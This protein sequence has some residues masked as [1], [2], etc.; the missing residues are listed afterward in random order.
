[1]S[2]S[3]SWQAR[4]RGV[5]FVNLATISWATNAVLGSWLRDD[6]GPLPL[7]GAVLGAALLDEPLG[8]VQLIFGG[9]ILGGG[10]W[11]TLGGVIGR[12]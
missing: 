11:A 6:I 4:A 7:Y 5:L 1:V 12:K 2:D 3:G 9:L 8:A 10:L